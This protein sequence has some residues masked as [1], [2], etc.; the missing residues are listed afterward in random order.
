MDKHLW[1]N[2]VIDW[3][4]FN[5]CYKIW[6]RDCVFSPVSPHKWVTRGHCC[7][8]S[9]NK[10]FQGIPLS[11]CFQKPLTKLTVLN[12]TKKKKLW[13][14]SFWWVWFG[15]FVVC[16]VLSK[17]NNY[18]LF[19]KKWGLF[20]FKRSAVP[21][22]F[23]LGRVGAPYENEGKSKYK[24]ILNVCLSWKIWIGALL[25][26]LPIANTNQVQTEWDKDLFTLCTVRY[27]HPRPN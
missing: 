5:C 25:Q 8:G 3:W 20:F 12:R 13:E 11:I 14:V 18:N 1:D 9:C 7:W 10:K 23:H 19:W 16:P 21:D 4:D 6:S 22:C 27:S 2:S 24:G 15:L 17:L 26:G